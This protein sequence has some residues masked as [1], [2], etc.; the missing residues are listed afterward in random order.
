[1]NSPDHRLSLSTVLVVD[2]D[3]LLRRLMTQVLEDAGYRVI[4]A[5][6]GRVAWETLVDRCG[7]ID[8]VVTDVM[9]PEMNGVELAARIAALPGAPPLVLVSAE[10]YPYAVLDHPFLPKPLQ[11]EQLVTIVGSIL[12]RWNIARWDRTGQWC[13]PP[14]KGANWN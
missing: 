11:P 8:A 6:N 7:N 4:A 12:G 1:M 5:E 3:D 9:M 10:P 2:D 14:L 13:L